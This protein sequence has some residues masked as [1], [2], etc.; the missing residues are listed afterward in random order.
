MFVPAFVRLLDDAAGH[1]FLYSKAEGMYTLY[2]NVLDNHEDKKLLELYLK[3][4]RGF[5]TVAQNYRDRVDRKYTSKLI[6]AAR[7]CVILKEATRR[8]C[9][10]NAHTSDETTNL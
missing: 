2:Q 7:H 9:G 3:Q 6:T 8:T 5:A 10:R 1:R 4:W